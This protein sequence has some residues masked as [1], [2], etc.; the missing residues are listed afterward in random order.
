[1]MPSKI[2]MN[3]T[4][5][6]DMRW[7]AVQF[8]D[9]LPITSADFDRMICQLVSARV[10]IVCYPTPEGIVVVSWKGRSLEC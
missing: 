4:L 6:P 2:R 10:P 5:S 9:R 7:L 3:N 8:P 1:M